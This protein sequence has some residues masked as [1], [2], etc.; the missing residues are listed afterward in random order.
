MK[1]SKNELKRLFSFV[2]LEK[3]RIIIGTFFLAIAGGLSLLL[4]QFV[5]TIFDDS[6]AD[7]GPS[8]IDMLAG[9]MA[10]AFIG[11]ALASSFRYYYFTVAGENIVLHIRHQLFQALIRQDI[12]FFDQS[13]TGELMSRLSS[14]AQV[15]QNAM[16]VNIS[17][18]LR[19]LA[20]VIGG[21]ALLF[22]TSSQLAIWMIIIVI[23]VS[24]LA[25]VYGRRL[26]V[27]SKRAQ[28]QLA[29]A[30]VVA[31]ES[32]S[33]IRNI[34]SFFREKY[35]NDKYT[36]QL[37]KYLSFSILKIRHVAFFL[38]F[39]SLFG[40]GAVVLVIWL[41][42]RLLIEQQMSIGDLTSFILYLIMVAMSVAALANLWADWMNATGAA[43][44]IFDLLDH[45]PT[46]VDSKNAKKVHLEGHLQFKNVSFSY[47]TRP[48]I[49]VLKNVSFDV[50]AGKIIA[51]VGPSGSGKS[52]IA[53]LVS[54][55]YDIHSGQIEMDGHDI[56]EIELESLR[57]Q[58][59]LV[60]QE[61]LLMSTS[62]Q[63]NLLY[64]KLDASE[65]EISDALR[66]ANATE[67]VERL[68]AKTEALVGEKGVQ[69][70]GG[71]KQRIA[72]AR[73]IL[74]NPKILILDEATSALDAE[75][76]HL[77]QQALDQIMK[78]RT[79]IVIAHR[80]STV[81]KAHQ[82]L[83]LDQGQIIQQGTHEELLKEQNSLYAQLVRRQF[84]AHQN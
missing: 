6:L 36:A 59:S 64:G 35:M 43:K 82:V 27:I 66:I 7:A 62:I 32:L 13:R 61:P 22:Y 45:S 65:Q 71:Q 51:L 33:G 70:S 18:V 28:D 67:F 12:S 55:F 69:L 52:T 84:E 80:L 23:P 10:L 11:Q 57:S 79:T 21:S 47:P 50:P 75:S 53:S 40:F 2:H 3:K 48:N 26:R 42:G 72:I 56:K 73:A 31:E 30:G 19:N 54:R 15:L 77:V 76:E 14:D 29:E 83:V 24:I 60:A 81:R 44:R 46:I 20:L 4:P 78:D 58:I 41:G 74:K 5:R 49:Q 39:A 68:P 38:F 16:S 37:Q 63:E 34:R 8:R 25:S 1:L 9:W 17:M